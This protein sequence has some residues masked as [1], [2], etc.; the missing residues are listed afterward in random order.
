MSK[1]FSNL[2]FGFFLIAAIFAGILIFRTVGF[3]AFLQNIAVWTGSPF[4]FV[5]EKSVGAVYGAVDFFVNLKDVSKENKALRVENLALLQRLSELKNDEADRDFSQKII[6]GFQGENYEFILARVI[7]RDPYYLNSTI[8][9]DKGAEDGV[10]NGMAAVSGGKFVIGQVKNAADSL[11]EI[12]MLSNPQSSASVIFQDSGLIG[13]AKGDRGLGIFVDILSLEEEVI[14]GESV[15][16]SGLDAVFPPGLVVGR[17]ERIETRQDG[18][19]RARIE[20][21]FDYKK[22]DRVAVMVK[23]N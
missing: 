3:P 12:L 8:L 13:V 21:P 1:R 16:T 15:A 9:I 4:V 14:A 23:N 17:V 10:K 2:K 19:R 11:S 22:I 5:G 18:I 7:G 6:S 20:L